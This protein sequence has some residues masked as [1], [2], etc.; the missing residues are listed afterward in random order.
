MTAIFKHVEKSSLTYI[1]SNGH[2]EAA[3]HK[4]SHK[5]DGRLLES[6]LRAILTRPKGN[7]SDLAILFRYFPYR[8]QLLLP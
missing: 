8:I 4:T 6:S 2:Q 5:I 1:K 7:L 3:N